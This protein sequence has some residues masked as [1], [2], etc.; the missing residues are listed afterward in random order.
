VQQWDIRRGEQRV[1]A[2]HD[3]LSL[4]CDDSYVGDLPLLR[5]ARPL[6]DE[7]LDVLGPLD[8][9]ITILSTPTEADDSGQSTSVSPSITTLRSTLDDAPPSPWPA[10]GATEIRVSIWWAPTRSF[11]VNVRATSDSRIRIPYFSSSASRD[12][13]SGVRSV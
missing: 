12:V 9:P 11:R 10:G 5:S 13:I 4:G 7:R 6:D 1:A 2:N 8:Q 3:V